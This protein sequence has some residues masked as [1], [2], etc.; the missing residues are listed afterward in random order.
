MNYTILAKTYTGRLGKDDDITV[1]RSG[2][3]FNKKYLGNEFV[4]FALNDDGFLCFAFK[5]TIGSYKLRL[6]GTRAYAQVGNDFKAMFDPASYFVT[7]RDEE[8]Y[9]TNCKKK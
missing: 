5:R 3:A 9:I 7:G 1:G 2:V 6:V 4:T 8:W